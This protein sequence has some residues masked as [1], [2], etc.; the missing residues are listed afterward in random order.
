LEAGRS[1]L[2]GVF[3][4]FKRTA[5]FVA[6]VITVGAF[7]YRLLDF[8]FSISEWATEK[9]GLWARL[10][11]G[12]TSRKGSL[13][14][15]GLLALFVV[16][17]VIYERRQDEIRNLRWK[18]RKRVLESRVR[19]LGNSKARSLTDAQ[20]NELY[21]FQKQIKTLNEKAL[22]NASGLL[23]SEISAWEATAGEFLETAFDREHRAY[24]MDAPHQPASRSGLSRYNYL[25][26]WTQKRLEKMNALND[27]LRVR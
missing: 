13:L 15:T 5:L 11:A 25:I 4:R 6:V 7:L 10:W 27:E 22:H 19:S 20:R 18:R 14:V 12:A 16:C 21:A 9:Q 17:L 24:V 8:L 3:R 23:D 2:R 1:R 26:G